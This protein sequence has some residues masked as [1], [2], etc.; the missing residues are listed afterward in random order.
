[1]PVSLTSSSHQS[2]LQDIFH[3]DGM[4]QA[5]PAMIEIEIGMIGEFKHSVDAH[6]EGTSTQA[7]GECSD[8]KRLTLVYSFTH[9]EEGNPT[10]LVTPAKSRSVPHE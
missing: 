6:G 8:T 2:G 9:R 4:R 10:D 1:M 7:T 5:S 3:C